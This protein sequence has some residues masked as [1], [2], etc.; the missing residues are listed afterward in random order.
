M[1]IALAV[2]QSVGGVIGYSL[3]THFVRSF[4]WAKLVL[5]FECSV[6]GTGSLQENAIRVRHSRA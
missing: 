6:N 1:Q 4:V 2:V 5:R 3:I